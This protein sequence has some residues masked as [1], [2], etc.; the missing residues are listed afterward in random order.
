MEAIYGNLQA[1]PLPRIERWALRLQPFEFTIKYRPGKEN[2]ADALSRLPLPNDKCGTNIADAYCYSVLKDATPCALQTSEI[3][4][5]SAEELRTLRKHIQE[6]LKYKCDK[7]YQ[8]IF[9]ELSTMGMLVMRGRRILMPSSLRKR[10]LQL[11]HEGHQGI[12]RTKQR[13]GVVAQY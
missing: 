10:T 12:V 6:G 13:Q 4:E 7:E 8:R 5:A 1:K 3:E 2:P 9:H 11:A